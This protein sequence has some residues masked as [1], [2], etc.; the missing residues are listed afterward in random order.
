MSQR[1]QPRL[2]PAVTAL[3]VPEHWLAEDRATLV[4]QRCGVRS[5]D[6]RVERDGTVVYRMQLGR[7]EGEAAEVVPLRGSAEQPLEGARRA[8]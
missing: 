3:P 1:R 8:R 7:D 4:G 2:A 6:L 5:T